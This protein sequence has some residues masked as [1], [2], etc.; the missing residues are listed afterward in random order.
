M[1]GK[2]RSTK[3][4]TFVRVLWFP[5]AVV[6]LILGW[7]WLEAEI[8]WRGDLRSCMLAHAWTDAINI[9]VWGQRI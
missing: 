2:L 6:A 1:S 7:L 9:F 3:V 5:A 4:A 8:G